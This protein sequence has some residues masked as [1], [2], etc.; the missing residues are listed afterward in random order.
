MTGKG[1]TAA[2]VSPMS[3]ALEENISANGTVCMQCGHLSWHSTEFFTFYLFY[4]I[5]IVDKIRS[6]CCTVFDTRFVSYIHVKG[7]FDVQD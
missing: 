5:P 2:A 4:V 7:K 1:P 3:A 6:S